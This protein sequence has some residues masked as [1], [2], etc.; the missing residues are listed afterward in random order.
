MCFS[1]EKR[2]STRYAGGLTV[3]RDS[4]VAALAVM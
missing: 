2:G 3:G 4:T 1:H